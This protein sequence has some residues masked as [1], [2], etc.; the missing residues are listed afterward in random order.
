M[1]ILGALV[2][3]RVTGLFVGA[4]IFSRGNV[5]SRFR[6]LLA[7]AIAASLL[8]VVPVTQP[9]PEDAYAVAGAMIGEIAIGLAIGLV[10]RM[11]LTAFQL[12]GAVIAFQMGFA[13]ANSFDPDSETSSPVIA[14]LHLG[15]VTLL[16]LILDG[17]HLLI[18]ALAASFETFPLA[19]GLAS[20]TLTRALLSGASS[21]FE[22]GVRVAAPVAGL[23]LLINAMIGFINR[24]TPQLSIFNIGFPMTVMGGLLAVLV[25]L[26]H[27][28]SF[29]LYA[30][31]D[32]QDQLV[33]MVQG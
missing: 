20:E 22:M 25:A 18:R 29:F 32:L 33:A 6:V 19:A 7:V 4:P 23:M 16:F 2:L 17:H 15:L 14:S 31:Q 12:A 27:V 26:P 13:L 24:V 11:V 3:A 9:L 5:P 21:M 28:A 10:A 30:Y 1:L 8:P